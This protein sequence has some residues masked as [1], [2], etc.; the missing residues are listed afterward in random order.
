MRI[1]IKEGE[2]KRK[3]IRVQEPKKPKRER[4][5]GEIVVC[6]GVTRGN[7]WFEE[8]CPHRTPHEHS[9]AC[10]QTFCSLARIHCCCK[11]S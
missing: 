9:K 2:P 3:R 6:S 8:R 10:L 7:C 1:R 4:I 5:K 11:K